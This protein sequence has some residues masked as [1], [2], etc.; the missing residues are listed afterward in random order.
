MFLNKTIETQLNH[1][2]VRKFKDQNIDKNILYTLFEVANQTSSS[3]GM[4]SYSIIRINDKDKRKKISEIC[5]QPYVETVPELLV[6]IVDVYRNARISE[7]MGEDLPNKN[8]MDR[9]FQGFTDGAIACQNV[10][11]AIES[12]G[13]G[14]VYLGS[15][16]NDSKALIELLNLPRLTF[17]I[18]GL[19]FGYP[20][21]NPQLK[22]R[23]DIPLKVFEDSYDIKDNYLESIKEY[24]REMQTYYDLRNQAKP[25]PPFS[26][27]VIAVLKNINENRSGILNIIKEQGFDFR[28]KD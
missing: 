10:V 15:T 21:Q 6:F 22:P 28:L 23:M 8:D 2:T 26:E 16:L 24:D 25:V 12:L 11:V 20:D 27:Q 14:A 5:K 3:M 4:Q 13:M 19:G 1:T 9:F 18:V 17:P 7:E